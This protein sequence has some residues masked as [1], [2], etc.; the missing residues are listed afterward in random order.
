MLRVKG[1]RIQRWKLR[2]SIHR[3]NEKGAHERKKWQTA[4]TCIQSDWTKPLMTHQYQ[5]L[6]VPD[7]LHLINNV[8][9]I[10]L[11]TCKFLH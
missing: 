6:E 10:L 8:S 5:I 1:K 4:Q 11:K 2:E 7:G 3:M 9:I